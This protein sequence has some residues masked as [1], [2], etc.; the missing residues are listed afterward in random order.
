LN[1]SSPPPINLDGERGEGR[2]IFFWILNLGLRVI[3][4]LQL[5]PQFYFQ[6]NYK[7][8]VKR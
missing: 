4:R 5:C 3:S 2:G 8:D 6:L 7:N 1:S